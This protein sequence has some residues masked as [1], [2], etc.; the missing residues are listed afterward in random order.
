MPTWHIFCRKPPY[1]VCNHKNAWFFCGKKAPWGILFC[2][3]FSTTESGLVWNFPPLEQINKR[4]KKSGEAGIKPTTYSGRAPRANHH[5]TAQLAFEHRRYLSYTMSEALGRPTEACIFF[6]HLTGARV[7]GNAHRSEKY[8][9]YIHH[10][11]Y[12]INMSFLHFSF[13]RVNMS[14][15]HDVRKYTYAPS[16]VHFYFSVFWNI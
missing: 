1:V 14:F 5:A 16:A 2:S 13:L 3:Q 11:N 15:L 7:R 9:R 6:S 4:N 12:K 8:Y 10:S